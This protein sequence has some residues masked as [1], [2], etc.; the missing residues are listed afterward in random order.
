MKL[1]ITIQRGPGKK[2]LES[3]TELSEE[4]TIANMKRLWEM[5]QFLNN[6]PGSDLRIHIN[7]TEEN[8]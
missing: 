2:P 4:L 8:E 6:L 7:L 3:I 5:E 1:E